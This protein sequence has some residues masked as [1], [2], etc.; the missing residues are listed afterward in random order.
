MRVTTETFKKKKA[1][2]TPITILTAYD[3]LTARLVEAGGVDAILVGDSLGMVLLGYDSTIPV[4]MDDMLHH[5]RAVV[6]GTD[7]VMVIGDMPFMSFQESVE[8]ALRNAGRF[9]KEAG[10]HAVKL[11]GGTSVASTVHRL[12]GAGIPVMGH[13]GLTPQSVH[14]FGGYKVQG[15]DEARAAE[16]IDD[17]IAL[18]EAGAFSVVLECVPAPLAFAITARLSIPTIGIGAGGGCDG[19]VLVLHDMLGLTDG[20][21]TFVKRYAG[22]GATT[23]DAVSTFVHDVINGAFPDEKH[24]FGMDEEVLA[25]VLDKVARGIRRVR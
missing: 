6:R 17:A 15:R 12:V 1:D 21:Y 23:Q 2:R 14:H 22:L 7:R 9:M 3:A 4:T 13:I 11:E 16:L 8:V 20:E 25:R 19:Q 5:A 10:V 18:Q 24:G